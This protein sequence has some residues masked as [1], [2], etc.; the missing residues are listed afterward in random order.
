MLDFTPCNW[1]STVEFEYSNGF[2]GEALWNKVNTYESLKACKNITR[3]TCKQY[4]NRAMNILVLKQQLDSVNFLLCNRNKD[5]NYLFCLSDFY[6]K[7]FWYQ[8]LALKKQ[9]IKSLKKYN[10]IGSNSL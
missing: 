4:E 10:A 2:R 9:C 3:N 8:L 6:C 1:L 7:I 5:T